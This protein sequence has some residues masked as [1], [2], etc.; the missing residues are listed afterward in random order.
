MME[1]CSGFQQMFKNALLK[2]KVHTCIIHRCVPAW[3]TLPTPLKN[4]LDS[5]MKLSITSNMEALTP[6]FSRDKLC[7]S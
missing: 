2:Q 4:V 1:S 3:R 5:T 6:K 7:R